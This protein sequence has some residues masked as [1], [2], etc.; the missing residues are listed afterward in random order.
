MNFRN[1]S[2][3]SD[4]PMTDSQRIQD[5]DQTFGFPASYQIFQKLFTFLYYFQVEI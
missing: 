3:L 1:K 2:D 4:Y 5:L